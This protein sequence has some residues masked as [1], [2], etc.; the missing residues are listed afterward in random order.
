MRIADCGCG[1]PRAKEE[2]VHRWRSHFGS[3]APAGSPLRGLAHVARLPA[4]SIHRL[5]RGENLWESVQS[6]DKTQSPSCYRSR[7]FNA[8]RR[9]R[10]A[11][12][13]SAAVPVRG[14]MPRP[15]RQRWKASSL[16]RA[17]N[18]DRRRQEPK[19]AAERGTG[20]AE[21]TAHGAERLV[22]FRVE[23]AALQF[24]R[25][26]LADDA[27]FAAEREADQ[28]Q[29]AAERR[30][31]HQDIGD[32]EER[33]E[34]GAQIPQK[35]QCHREDQ[36][37]DRG[38]EFQRRTFGRLLGETEADAG[39][40]GEKRMR[41]G[42]DHA[43]QNENEDRSAQTRLSRSPGRNRE[44]FRSWRSRGRPSRRR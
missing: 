16:A 31:H 10:N 12:S 35:M 18:C 19:P 17:W 38:E 22:S 30:H 24:G 14:R 13:R 20:F 27:S 5:R 4:G 37:R 42:R 40:A 43:A 25:E 8:Y 2:L 33:A 44:Y 39:H 11:A 23:Q 41:E 6:V 26:M 15:V 1:F 29:H 9:C 28:D 36:T 34:A 3:P 21:A 7:F 32:K